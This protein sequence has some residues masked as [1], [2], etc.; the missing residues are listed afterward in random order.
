MIINSREDLDNAPK[1]ERDQFMR[2]LA[3]TINNWTWSG[4]KW[5]LHKT[6]NDIEK[7]GFTESD[8]P[9][10]PVPEKPTYNPDERDAQRAIEE[11]SESRRKAYRDESDPLFFKIQRGEATEAEWLASVAEIKA[12][13]PKP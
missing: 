9:N 2:G 7:F 5:V 13:Y 12:R 6:L 8:F 11:A 1:E 3:S 4:V 10:A